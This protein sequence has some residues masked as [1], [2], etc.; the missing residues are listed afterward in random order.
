MLFTKPR[1]AVNHAYVSRC[2]EP[3]RW[4][5]RHF[6]YSQRILYYNEVNI[7]FPILLLNDRQKYYLRIYMFNVELTVDK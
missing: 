4:N 6:F 2:Y 3:A 5:L 1:H 7:I